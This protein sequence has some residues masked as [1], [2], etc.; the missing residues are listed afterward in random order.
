MES[1]VPVVQLREHV[2]Q[3]GGGHLLQIVSL[4]LQHC[5]F[6]HL[7][8]LELGQT[9]LL[10][11]EEL[12]LGL[13][14][15]REEDALLHLQLGTETVFL[16]LLL[17]EELVPSLLHALH[18][19]LEVKLLLLSKLPPVGLHELLEA[20]HLDPLSILQRLQQ[21]LHLFFCLLGDELAGAH[22]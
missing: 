10:V 21:L 12:V 5:S 15:H 18:E 1:L 22:V 17:L 14:L 11:G 19:V 13:L 20:Q 4:R 3:A 9:Q 16:V 6:L 8:L 7:L 2:G